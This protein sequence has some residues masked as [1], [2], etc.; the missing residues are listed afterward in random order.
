MA[1]QNNLSEC[2]R[3]EGSDENY[4]MNLVTP[5]GVL[6]TVLPFPNL[7][8]EC[9]ACEYIGQKVNR[10]PRPEGGHTGGH[11]PGLRAPRSSH[12][13][14]VLRRWGFWRHETDSLVASHASI[15]RRAL[16]ESLDGYLANGLPI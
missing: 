15:I 7:S 4:W 13:C 12:N 1:S 10:S 9:F 2:P 5:T 11:P 14:L 6:L 8:S 3:A 16:R